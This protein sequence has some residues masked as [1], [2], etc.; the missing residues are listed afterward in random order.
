MGVGAVR[1]ERTEEIV[2]AAEKFLGA[3]GETLISSRVFH[4]PQPIHLP[5]HLGCSIPQEVHTNKVLTFGGIKIS[6][7]L[8]VKVF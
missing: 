5:D 2:E 3:V 8:S 7:P 4:S 1:F 6:R